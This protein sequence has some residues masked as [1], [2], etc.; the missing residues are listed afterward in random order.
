MPVYCFTCDA[1]GPF[2]VRRDIDAAGSPAGCPRCGSLGRRVF[3]PPA[4]RRVPGGLR[5]ARDGEERSAY[6]P[7]V[8]GAPTGRPVR[9]GHRH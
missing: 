2:E 5:R 6:E 4:V 7:Q 9:L 1:C 3:T 8:V